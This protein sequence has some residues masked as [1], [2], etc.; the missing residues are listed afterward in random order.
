[1]A[2]PTPEDLHLPIKHSMQGVPP[3]VDKI[4]QRELDLND[5][6]IDGPGLAKILGTVLSRLGNDQRQNWL[7]IERWGTRSGSVLRSAVLFVASTD[8]TQTER[9]RADLAV[10]E[11]TGGSQLNTFMAANPGRIIVLSAGIFNLDAT[12][13]IPAGTRLIGTGNANFSV[14]HPT[15]ITYFNP[16]TGLDTYNPGLFVVGN[17]MAQME[18]G[19]AVENVVILNNFGSDICAF[20][21]RDYCRVEQVQCFKDSGGVWQF[22]AVF[23]GSHLQIIDVASDANNTTSGPPTLL[24]GSV[25]DSIIEHVRGFQYVD[26]VN[27]GSGTQQSNGPTQAT[28]CL[29]VDVDGAKTL[30][31]DPGTNNVIVPLPGG[32]TTTLVRKDLVPALLVGDVQGVQTIPAPA[33]GSTPT[34]AA[35]G[36]LNGTYPNPT[37]AGR[38]TSTDAINKDLLP[39]LLAGDVQGVQTIPTPSTSVAGTAVGGSLAGTLVNPTFAGR[40]SS[41]DKIN[42]DLLPSLLTDGTGVVTYPTPSATTAVGGSLAGTLPNPTFAGRDSSVDQINRDLLPAALHGPLAGVNTIPVPAAGSTPTGAAGG[43]LAGTYPNPLFAGRNTSGDEI[44]KD[45]TLLFMCMGT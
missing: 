4:V 6:Q 22:A 45:C 1:M 24:T 30:T 9:D 28:R 18:A 11:L 21:M 33:A 34:G 26:Q 37:F 32:T 14:T 16:Y 27:V 20:G 44:N 41:V 7:E 3:M 19:S 43:S 13:Q 40:D 39:A 31:T 8:A 2:T 36:S 35:G 23:S 42:Q 38:D 10:D 12:L 17:I 5:G 15:G 25:S 29:I